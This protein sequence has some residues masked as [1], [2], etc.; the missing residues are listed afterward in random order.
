MRE[1]RTKDRRKEQGALEREHEGRAGLDILLVCEQTVCSW[2]GSEHGLLPSRAM[3]ESVGGRG[4]LD[5]Q[6]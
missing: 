3:V 5:S 2:A 1:E 6:T 4:L